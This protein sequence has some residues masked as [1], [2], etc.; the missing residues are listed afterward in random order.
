MN[1]GDQLLDD[2]AV[3]QQCESFIY[4]GAVTL[5]AEGYLA[6]RVVLLVRHVSVSCGAV[7]RGSATSG[8]ESG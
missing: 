5:E 6:D 8:M 3:L 7:P 1:E 4:G 2:E